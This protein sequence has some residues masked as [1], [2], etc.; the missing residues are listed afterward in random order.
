M[1][2]LLDRETRITWN[3]RTDSAQVQTSSPRVHK[4]MQKLGVTPFDS[5]T[6]SKKKTTAWYEVPKGWIKFRKPVVISE[7]RRRSL[8]ERAMIKLHPDKY[9]K[10]S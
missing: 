7:E 6:V 5:I 1:D 9:Q 2:V 10:A 8:S 3:D 4:V